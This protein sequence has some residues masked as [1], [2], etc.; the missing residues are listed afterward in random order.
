MVLA[1][2][3]FINDDRDYAAIGGM[4]AL[5]AKTE[6]QNADGKDENRVIPPLHY[7]KH[8]QIQLPAGVEYAIEPNL[9]FVQQPRKRNADHGV[10][11]RDNGV[12]QHVGAPGLAALVA[13]LLGLIVLSV[14]CYRK[15]EIRA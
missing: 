3:A 15:A 1:I 2:N 13:F 7:A 5:M 9:K 11:D 12:R 8:V 14:L 4:M 6:V 10:E